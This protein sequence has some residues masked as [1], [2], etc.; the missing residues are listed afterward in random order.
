MGCSRKW[1]RRLV[2]IAWL[3]LTLP[4]VSCG[5]PARPAVY[6]VHG[7]VLDANDKP[8]VGALVIFHP[9]GATGGEALKPLGYVDADGTFA[10]TTFTKGDGAPAGEY[11]LTIEWHPPPANPFAKKETADQLQGRYGDPQ[12]SNLS[13]TVAQQP[14]NT[15][16]PIRLQ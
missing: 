3:G 11:A 9:K 13:F 15:I 4:L 8:A 12:T 6:P 14:D 16:P 7:Q 1:P 5:K 10:L 2:V